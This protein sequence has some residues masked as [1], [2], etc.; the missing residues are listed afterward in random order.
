MSGLYDTDVVLWSAH[1]AGLLRHRAAGQLVSD[2]DLDWFN[3]AEEIEALG[4][5][6][7]SRLRSLTATA[8]EHLMR[9]EASPAMDPR[10]G[11]KAMINRTRRDIRDLLKNSPSL[12]PLIV[13]MVADQAQRA[14]ED[15]VDWLAEHGEQ[16]RVD[17]G[18]LSFTEDQVLGNWFPADPA[19]RDLFSTTH[20]VAINATNCA[21]QGVNVTEIL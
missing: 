10:R 2:A 15:L 5:S 11:W 12:R 9:L 1:Q 6:E 8:I 17:I 3:I 13:A 16:P 20:E 21:S 18:R 19:S 14:R 4:R 7:R